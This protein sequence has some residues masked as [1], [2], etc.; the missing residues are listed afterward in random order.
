MKERSTAARAAMP[1]ALLVE[2]ELEGLEGV[3]L[4]SPGGA[5]RGSPSS[6]PSSSR[7]PRAPTG[8]ARP[9]RAWRATC[10]RPRRRSRPISPT[11][12]PLPSL[13]SRG[14]AAKLQIEN[15][16]KKQTAE[17]AGT[18]QA[19]RLRRLNDGLNEKA[20]LALEKPQGGAGREQPEGQETQRGHRGKA[21]EVPGGRRA[22]PR[23]AEG[24][25]RPQDGLQGQRQGVL[26]RP[27]HNWRPCL[28][29]E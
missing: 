13:L 17:R 6:L 4:L 22:S 29:N 7:A 9:A 28:S 26:R 16:A 20:S 2:T 3:K 8:S 15:E 21:E 1:A 27:W 25:A 10:A 23:R 14:R 12:S 5:R 18:K 19:E 24:Q 11:E